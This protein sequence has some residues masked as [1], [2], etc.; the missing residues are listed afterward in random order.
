[1]AIKIC[2]RAL[3]YYDD[4]YL[5]DGSCRGHNTRICA[6]EFPA[7]VWLQIFGEEPHF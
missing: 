1:M 3:F 7:H 4:K 5:T 2:Y 6:V